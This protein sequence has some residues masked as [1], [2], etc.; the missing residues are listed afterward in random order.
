MTEK[1][2]S[3]VKMVIL[4][5]KDLAMTPG[6]VAA[7]VAHAVLKVFMDK[8][9]LSWDEHLGDH[10]RVPTPV[11]ITEWLQGSYAKVCLTVESEAEMLELVAK[12]ESSKIW[13]TVITDEGRTCLHGQHKTVA[14]IGPYYT[15]AINLIT[16]HL[17]L[18]R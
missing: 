18:Y 7:Q 15:D 9:V 16:G 4:V 5:R 12:S 8:S 17:K 10:R 2:K 14:A 1:E 13:T 6:K 3:E 11:Y